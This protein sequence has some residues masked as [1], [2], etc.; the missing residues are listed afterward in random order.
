MKRLRLFVFFLFFSFLSAFAEQKPFYVCT[1]SDSD[2]FPY[3]INLINSIHRFNFDKLGEVAVFDLGCTHEQIK[4]LQSMKKVSVYKIEK[5]HKDLLKH[6]TVNYSGKKVRGWYAW[7]PVAMKQ[8]LDMFPYMVYMDAGLMLLRPMDELF[9]EVWEKD[10]L[11][12]GV[13]HSIAWMTPQHVVKTFDLESEERNWILNEKT[14]GVAGGFM[15]LT[16]AMYDDFIIPMYNL[17]HDINHF[18]DDGTTPD[19][20]GT[21]RHDQVLFSVIGR[22]LGLK[23]PSWHDQVRVKLPNGFVRPCLYKDI[24]I[25]THHVL[26]VKKIPK[27]IRECIRY[28]SSNE[29][30][31]QK[32]SVFPQD[33]SFLV[34]QP[35]CGTFDVDGE[36]IIIDSFI[37]DGDLVFDVGANVGK[38]SALVLKKFCPKKLFAFEPI[39]GPYA[40]CCY[41]LQNYADVFNCAL[42]SED[43]NTVQFYAYTDHYN[44]VLSSLYQRDLVEQKLNIEPTVLS[45]ATRT[46]D[47]FCAEHNIGHIDFLKIDTEGAEYDV[48]FGASQLL[49]KKAIASIQFEYGLTYKDSNKTLKQVVKLL[50]EYGYA[51]FKIYPNFIV[52]IK[53]WED[54]LERY[55]QCNYLALDLPEDSDYGPVVFEE[56]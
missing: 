36:G 9:E 34:Q 35:K 40:S 17:A 47:S 27:K 56:I 50:S 8:M 29:E 32:L 42:Y 28:K 48:L 31:L 43:K 44:G 23:V 52:H 10:Y 25:R 26:D 4:E 15:G 21:A 16:C 46:L 49:D 38:W 11:V 1:S 55:D 12:A 51:L 37:R 54:Y 41:A 33:K 39:P 5:V 7:K 18:I 13:G 19:G 24:V 53:Q 30:N 3:L 2:Y 22:L 45:V 6:F 14:E 20:F